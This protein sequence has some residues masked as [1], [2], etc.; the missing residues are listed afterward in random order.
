[1]L[2]RTLVLPN[3][4]LLAREV[5]EGGIGEFAISVEHQAEICV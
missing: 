2:M 5:S 1:M 4:A 3:N